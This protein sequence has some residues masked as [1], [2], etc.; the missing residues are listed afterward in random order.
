MGQA[1]AMDQLE[2]EDLL[3]ADAE[4]Q[5]AEEKHLKAEERLKTEHSATP[6]STAINK[7]ILLCQYKC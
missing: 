6:M 4:D 1:K 3:K 2:E 7:L 5:L